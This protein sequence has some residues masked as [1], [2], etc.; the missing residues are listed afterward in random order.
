MILRSTSGMFDPCPRERFGKRDGYM[1]SRHVQ[2]GAEESDQQVRRTVNIV[3][4]WA[5]RQVHFVVTAS[6]GSLVV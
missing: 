1:Y 3:A 6:L 2:E 4:C 5:R